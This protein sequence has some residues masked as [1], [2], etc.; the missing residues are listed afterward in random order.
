MGHYAQLAPA[1]DLRERIFLATLREARSITTC[2]DDS[3]RRVDN[4]GI[5]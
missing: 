3:V 4:A 5:G 2:L 1:L